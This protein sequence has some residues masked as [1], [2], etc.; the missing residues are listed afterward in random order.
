MIRSSSVSRLVVSNSLGHHNSKV[1]RLSILN[2]KDYPELSN[3]ALN[4]ITSTLLIWRPREILQRHTQG[5]RQC[6]DGAEK[7]LKM[8]A[9]KMAVMEPQA[10]EPWQPPEA[11]RSKGHILS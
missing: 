2:W 5:R 11:G 3:W 8:L 6:K 9:L 7:E 1:I 10:K 4:A